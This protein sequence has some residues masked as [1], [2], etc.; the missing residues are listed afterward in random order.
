MTK[1][2]III[3][4][5]DNYFAAGVDVLYEIIKKREIFE[6][7]NSPEWIAGAVC[8]ET[9]IIPVFD[10]GVDSGEYMAIIFHK[11]EKAVLLADDII[12]AYELEERGIK[13]E[14]IVD[15]AEKMLE[16]EAVNG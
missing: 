2:E 6:I 14:K 4:I 12:K 13:K 10:L 9:E 3:K 5:S 1:Y 16:L 15:I 11:G 7:P 8:F